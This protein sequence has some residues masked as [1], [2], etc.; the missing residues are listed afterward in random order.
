[1]KKIL[2]LIP[3]FLV[4]IC[5]ILSATQDMVQTPY[6][7]TAQFEKMKSLAGHWKGTSTSYGKTEPAEVIYETSS[8]QSVVVEKLFPGTP[9]EMVSVY[10]DEKGRLEMTH[11]CMLKNHPELKSVAADRMNFC[12]R[13]RF[14]RECHKQR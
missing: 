8:A 7:G 1:M 12:H 10:R 14:F 13:L 3:F 6:T 9:H 5:A 2:I 11:Y 4:S